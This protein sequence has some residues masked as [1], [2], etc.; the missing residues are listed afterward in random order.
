M[1]N[2]QSRNVFKNKVLKALNEEITILFWS[3]QIMYKRYW[4]YIL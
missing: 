2:L 4:L 3:T 1:M